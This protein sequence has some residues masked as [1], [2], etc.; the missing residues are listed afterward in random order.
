VKKIL[1]VTS[2]NPWNNNYGGAIRNN[3][4][5]KAL[6]KY[7]DL[8]VGLTS[9]N[10]I[11]RESFLKFAPISKK[12]LHLLMEES[13]CTHTRK[14]Q[15]IINYV[16]TLLGFENI[17]RSFFT[18][19]RNIKPDLVWYFQKFSIR[20]VGFPDRIPSI[21]DLDNVNWNLLK[22]TAKF[23][24][25]ISKYQT[26]LKMSLSYIE[27]NMLIRKASFTTISNP[28]ERNKLPDTTK[29][30]TINNGFT[31]PKNLV[32]NQKRNQRILFFGSLFYYPN[33]DG[34]KWFCGK[35]WPIIISRLPD[36]KLDIIGHVI[37]LGKIDNVLKLG[38]IKYHGFV[39]DIDY[40]IKSNAFLIV[41]LR[42]ASGTRIKILESWAK[43][44]PVVSTSLGAEGLDATNHQTILIGDTPEEFAEACLRLLNDQHLGIQLARNAYQTNKV[45][46]NWD[47]IFQKIYNVTEDF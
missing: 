5:I 11:E 3:H 6:G 41:P 2:Q 30:I 25:G 43:G 14:I 28:E 47:T 13:S 45:K 26:Y 20:S 4:I 46:F 19:L 23:Q 38:N 42:I 17:N 34:L 18:T 40:F 39:E 27:E 10:K 8:H 1:Y 35:V 32:I 36:S 9:T 15:I 22:R 24:S 16:S 31:F 12:N 21:L 7:H 44:L 29:V 37:E 33:L